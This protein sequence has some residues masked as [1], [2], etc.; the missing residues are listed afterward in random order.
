MRHPPIFGPA[1]ATG[2]DRSAYAMGN[3]GE[4]ICETVVTGRLVSCVVGPSN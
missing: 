3:I 1:G 2:R 4:S